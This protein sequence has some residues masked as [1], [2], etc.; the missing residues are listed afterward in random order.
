MSSI[1]RIGDNRETLQTIPGRM[2]DLIE[3]PPGCNFHP[4]CPYAEEVCARKEPELVDTTTGQPAD[5]SR[6]DEQSAACLAYTGDLDDKLDYEV[7]VAR[8]EEPPRE[9]TDRTGVIP[10]DD[11][12]SNS[13][14]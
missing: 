6:H 11:R 2:P 5:V 12:E 3:M 9:N 13:N 8:A 10:A 1:P 7:T 4:R 14:E